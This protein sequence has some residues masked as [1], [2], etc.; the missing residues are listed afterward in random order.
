[1]KSTII[2][3]VLS[4]LA[5]LYLIFGQNGVMKF[6][7]L[8]KVRNSYI[9]KS[10]ELED[11]IKKT[12]NEIE[13]LKSDK[14]YLEMVIKKRLNMKKSDEDLFIIDNGSKDGG[15]DIHSN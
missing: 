6:Y 14:E 9:N 2:Y 7:N 15:K 8:I 10:E 4:I 11:K 1:M 3:I 5:V 13:Y 12:E